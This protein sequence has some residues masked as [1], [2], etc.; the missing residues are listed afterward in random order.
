MSKKYF[1]NGDAHNTR[2]SAHKTAFAAQMHKKSGHVPD[3]LYFERE[4]VSA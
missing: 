2:G 4:K 3:F 1:V